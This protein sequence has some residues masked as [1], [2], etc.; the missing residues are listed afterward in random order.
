MKQIK[1]TITILATLLLIVTMVTGLL[2]ADFVN[3]ATSRLSVSDKRLWLNGA[4]SF[5]VTIS[6]RTSN[7][8]LS[9]WVADEEALDITVGEWN[10]D[11]CTVDLTANKSGILRVIVTAAGTQKTVKVY[12]TPLHDMT[13]EEIY[14]YAHDTVVEIE[15]YDRKGNLYMGAGFFIGDG[16]VLTNH[17]VVEAAKTIKITD[18]NGKEYTA[19]SV[20]GFDK[21]KDLILIQVSK[22]NTAA[23]NIAES[24]KGG[25]RIYSYGSPLC[26]TGTFTQGMIANPH[27][28][29]DGNNYVQL[30]MPS[31][32]GSGG[33]PIMDT[34]GR[35]VGVMCLVVNG[36]QNMSFAVDYATIREFL[37]EL[38]DDTAMSMK[39]F[40][41]TTK[42][43]TKESN[44]YDIIGSSVSDNNA[45]VYTSLFSEST[46]KDIYEQAHDAMV[47]IVGDIY[48]L[49]EDG[50]VKLEERTIGSGFF[51]GLDTIVTNH[52]VLAVQGVRDLRAKDYNGHTYLFTS[53]SSI[54]AYDLGIATVTC[55]DG[56][57]HHTSLDVW[58]GYIPAGGETVYAFGNPGGYLCTFADGVVACP[59]RTL[60][61]LQCAVLG[62]STDLRFIN[63]TAPITKGSSG[64]PLLNK[65]GKVIGVNTV[66]IDE[67][68]ENNYAVQIDQLSKLGKLGKAGT[69]N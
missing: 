61:D 19:K 68:E 57:D 40:Y 13:S 55:M 42:G 50:S 56:L 15:T 8:I 32:V 48:V 69:G 4:G 51:I 67:I 64:G 7:D 31:G 23:L 36:A 53:V 58:P 24:V 45:V 35:V 60:S 12:A 38:N 16:L 27:V 10:G 14:D 46:S 11:T 62:Y 25:Q 44:F 22:T 43:Q 65:Y 5:E 39:K 30:A 20:L 17:H 18:Y 9:V 54:A 33:G 41:K 63:F 66:T 3:A 21:E 2:P 1:K 59:T 52:H 29:I 49:Y 26:I 34:Q 47:A 6:E 28:E 37:G